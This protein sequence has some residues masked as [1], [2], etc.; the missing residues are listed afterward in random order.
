MT[1]VNVGVDADANANT[2]VD[3]TSDIETKARRLGWLPKEEFRGD[4]TRWKPADE[5]VEHGETIIPILKQ[6]TETLHEKL[7]AQERQINEMRQVMIEMRDHT[8]RNTERMYAQ[9]RTD[10]EAEMRAAVETADTT[11]FDAA[12]ARMKEIEA[13]PSYQSNDRQAPAQAPYVDPV[14]Q[15]WVADNSWFNNDIVLNGMAQGIHMQLCRDKPGLSLA[16][17]LAEV[18]REVQARF[19]E[20]FGNSRRSDAPAVSAPGGAPP[21]RRTN[22]RTFDDLP[23]DAKDA[24]T[25]FSKMMPGYSKEEYLK[26]YVWD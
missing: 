17:N 1:E 13:P 22:K 26:N 2:Q 8:R 7:S 15:R 20:K 14:V 21:A 10:V 19:P 16:D 5:Y 11:R 6:N 18:T 24:Y 23:Q 3:Q 9:A 25:K 4:P 12:K